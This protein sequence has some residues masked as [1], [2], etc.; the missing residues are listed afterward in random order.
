MIFSYS[1]ISRV[2]IAD[3][4]GLTQATI[5]NN[6]NLLIEDGLIQEI[7]QEENP[8]E[9]SVGRHPIM[10]AYK[11]D[12][13][14]VIGV[15]INPY[16]IYLVVLNGC[17]DHGCLE[18]YAG[19]MAIRKQCAEVIAKK[20]ASILK[21]I[22]V[23]S[24][25]PTINEIIT[26]ANQGDKIVNEILD[27]AMDYLSTGICNIIKFINPALVIVDAYLMKLER[28]KDVLQN[29]IS[30]HL[31]GYGF[32]SVTL[33]VKEHDKSGGGKASASYAFK[34]FIIDA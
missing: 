1:P 26:A 33:E 30:T 29:K 17:G 8:M 10:L 32:N 9:G 15:E 4:L 19:E 25:S 2:E 11:S 7:N 21:D 6:V 14:Y 3:L 20:Q 18:T 31:E 23:N 22:V 28:L 13:K 5:S 34:K 27:Q 24:E 12:S 16:G